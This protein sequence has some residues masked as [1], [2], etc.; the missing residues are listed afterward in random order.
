MRILT[1]SPPQ[2]CGTVNRYEV[3]YT[4]AVCSASDVTAE[5]IQINE[6]GII[7]PSSDVY[8][9]QVRAV[10]NENCSSRYSTCAQVA[11][12]EHGMYSMR[13]TPCSLF[14][15]YQ[16]MNSGECWECKN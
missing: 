14:G 9:I 7:L 16:L 8:C 3:L 4:Q 11:S 5:R 10:V 6:T 2:S 13:N 15:F 12:L 1:W